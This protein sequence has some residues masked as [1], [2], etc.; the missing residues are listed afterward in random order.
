MD[1]RKADWRHRAMWS[2]LAGLLVVGCSS[3]APA[4]AE[5]KPTSPTNRT[6]KTT[7]KPTPP[8]PR[9]RV[10]DRPS[11]H[12]GT[13]F[14][15]EW[16]HIETGKTT[17]H[18]SPAAFKKDLERLYDAGFRPVTATEYLTGKM[19]LPPG[20]T[21]VVMTFDDSNPSQFQ[22]KEDGTVDPECG[23]GI[24]KAFA[25]THPDF[26]VHGTFYVLPDVMWGQPKS[27][28]KKI[29]MLEEMG[30]ELANHT[31]SHP[32]LRKLSDDRAKAEIVDAN[33]RLRKF[34]VKGPISL[35]LPF[36]VSPKNKG[37]VKGLIQKGELSAAFLVGANPAPA[38]GKISYPAVP[39]IQAY[40]GP[41]GL[42]EWLDKLEK[43]Q[44][45]VYVE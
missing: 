30:S 27:V 44:V 9:K 11:N 41:Y 22:L 17:M 20:A 5:E 7:E 35:A 10:S 25:E 33:A 13:V 15:A 8:I 16:H 23:I 19:D 6:T 4:P 26:P 21:P 34:G 38:P 39:R 40:D 36:G 24:W 12:E 1:V 42:P 31:V 37:I 32:I 28:K 43:G 29:A 45:K 3:K 2:V 14:V 18:R